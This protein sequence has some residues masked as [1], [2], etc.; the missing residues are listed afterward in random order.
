MREWRRLNP[1]KAKFA[2]LRNNA[3]RRGISFELTFAEFSGLAIRTGY[4]QHA[5]SRLAT[6]LTLDRIDHEQGYR[7]DNLRVIPHLEN[8]T[9]GA[10]ERWHG[11]AH[12]WA[13]Q[14]TEAA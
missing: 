10:V 9:K 2:D 6:D 8:S 7:L 11:S 14:K 12:W 13:L 3:R 4:A 5:G 1:L